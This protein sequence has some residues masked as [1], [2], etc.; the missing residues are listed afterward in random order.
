MHD[1]KVLP[2]DFRLDILV[3]DKVIIELKSVAEMKDVFHKQL[4]TYLRVAKK[5][6]GILVNFSTTDIRKSI[7]QSQWI[8]S[9]GLKVFLVPTDLLFS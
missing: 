1:G 8:Y 6:L 4:L 7:F 2:V 9:H 5:H 3:E